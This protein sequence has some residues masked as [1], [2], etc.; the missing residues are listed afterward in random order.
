MVWTDT[1]LHGRTHLY[2][3]KW[4]FPSGVRYM[5]AALEHYVHFSG[6][7]LALIFLLMD[8]NTWQHKA[9]LL[10]VFLE[11]E[12]IRLINKT[13]RS[14]T[15]TPIEHVWDSLV[16]TIATLNSSLQIIQGRKTF[17]LTSC[18]SDQLSDRGTNCH[19]SNFLSYFQY[20]IVVWG[21]FISKKDLD[22]SI[23]LFDCVPKLHTLRLRLLLRILCVCIITVE[24]LL[25]VLYQS[26]FKY[27]SLNSVL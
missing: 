19:R 3:F 8:D 2:F 17:L 1:M 16:R 23:Y 5:N 9:H 4:D 18:H 13:A 6:V 10:D 26:M 22:Y 20:G 12:D 11:T 27:I 24:W 14:E 21:L 25:L 15:S 7:Q